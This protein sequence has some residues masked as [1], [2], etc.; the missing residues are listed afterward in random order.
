MAIQQEKEWKGSTFGN[1]LM[2]RALIGLLRTVDIRFIYFFAYVF[3]LPPNLLRP[4]YRHAY[5]F[6]HERLGYSSIK[7]LYYAYKNHCMFVQVV[8][9][10]FAMYAGKQF[11]LELEGYEYF[12]ELADGTD[13]FVQLSSH[14]GNYEIAGY[15]LVAE[16]KRFNALVY[17]GEKEEIMQ[18]REKLFSRTN[19]HMIPLRQDMSHL[20]EINSALA[21]GETVSIPADRI[22]GSNKYVTRQFLGREAHFPMGPFQVIALRGIQALAVNVMKVSYNCYKTYVTPLEYDRQAPRQTQIQQISEAYVKELE[23]MLKQYPTQWYNYFDFW[24]Q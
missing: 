4:G 3:V 6:F 15:T 13:G 5:R 8:I 21:N 2:H 9:D 16:K 20:F 24:S 11:K 1:S 14:I 7:S 23:R 18:N 19:I 10:K 17:F 22:W 12:Q